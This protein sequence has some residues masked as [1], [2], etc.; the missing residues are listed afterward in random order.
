MKSE[1]L[2]DVAID[3]WEAAVAALLAV[4]ALE[5]F[6]PGFASRFFNPSLL[7]CAAVVASAVALVA[8]RPGRA[9]PARSV[10]WPLAA[11]ALLAPLIAWRLAGGLAS[12]WRALTAAVVLAAVAA[13]WNAFSKND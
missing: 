12:V 7:V 3:A 5:T 4:V 8:H 11:L 10:R 9:S 1:L 6:E 13:I 2:R